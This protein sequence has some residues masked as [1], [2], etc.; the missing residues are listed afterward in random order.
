MNNRKIGENTLF[1]N[2]SAS[3]FSS[4]ELLNYI[5]HNSL[6]KERK[7]INSWSC[8]S[9]N[10]SL[11]A[12]YYMGFFS[13]NQELL[14]NINQYKQNEKEYGE[15]IKKIISFKMK[16]NEELDKKNLIKEIIKGLNFNP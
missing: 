12:L 2:N 9:Y 10:L 11:L 8:Q 16:F 3:P 7:E 15:F 13:A 5:S 14:F 4:P 1:Q 6:S